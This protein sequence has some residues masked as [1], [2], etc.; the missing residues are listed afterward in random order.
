MYRTKETQINI[1]Y[2]WNGLPSSMPL[3]DVE[4]GWN[5]LL[6]FTFSA[7]QA[8]YSSHVTLCLEVGTGLPQDFTF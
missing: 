4:L 3:T 6:L 5:L 1:I 2:A 7:P 8:S